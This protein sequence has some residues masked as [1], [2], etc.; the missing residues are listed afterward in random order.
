M[1]GLDQAIT[2]YT[3]RLFLRYFRNGSTGAVTAPSLDLAQDADL[4]RGHWAI[5]APVRRFLEYILTHRHEAQSLL[6]FVRRTDDAMARGRIDARATV[7]ARAVGGHPSLVVAEEPLRSFNTGPNQLVAWVV[8]QA[9]LQAARL[10]HLQSPESHYRMLIEESM[11]GLSAVKR[12]DALREPLKH[13]V[14]NRRPTPGALREAGRSRRVLYREA[15]AAYRAFTGVEAGEPKAL[16]AVLGSTVIAPLEAWRRYELA[17]A[18]GIGMALAAETG[19]ALR[20]SILVGGSGEPILRCG[21]YS[22]YWQQGTDLFRRPPLEPSEER[23]KRALAAYGMTLSADRPDLVLVDEI[24]KMVIAVIEVKY[25]LG[26]TAPVRFREAVSQ[27]VRYARGYAPNDAETECLIG[28]SL[29]AL[30]ADA[31]AQIASE[32]ASPSTVDFAG[33][34][35]GALNSWVRDVVMPA[36]H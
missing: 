6:Q 29:V 25:L 17:V 3:M 4:L 33:L 15:V 14:T 19:A 18:M 8:H 30:S 22:L 26:D 23:L 32:T 21:Q 10:L 16:S 9:S 13:V 31:P 7:L 34:Q 1:T 24:A 11:A 5:S 12:L 36:S 2:D 28:R 20:L 35:G 27:I